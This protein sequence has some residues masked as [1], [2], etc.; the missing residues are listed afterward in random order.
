MSSG[1]KLSVVDLI[2]ERRGEAVDVVVGGG[3]KSFVHRRR[4]GFHSAVVNMN[5]S[6]HNT[7]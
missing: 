5:L 6:Y 7:L 3:R 4:R 2:K 1:G